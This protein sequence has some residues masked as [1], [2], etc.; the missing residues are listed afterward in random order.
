MLPV[1][2]AGLGTYLPARSV[3]S[4]ELEEELKLPARWIERATGVRERRRAG[5]ETSVEMAAKA[6]QEA[7][8]DAGVQPAEI[9]LVT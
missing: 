1:K 8:R 7:L 9:D 4:R 6:G 3:S 5:G 2:I